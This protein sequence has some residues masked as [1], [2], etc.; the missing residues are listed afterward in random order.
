M[1]LSPLSTRAGIQT[2][3]LIT[4]QNPR[5]D[6]APFIIFLLSCKLKS[7]FL[8]MDSV[9]EIRLCSKTQQLQFPVSHSSKEFLREPFVK[10][11][12]CVVSAHS[13]GAKT[14]LTHDKKSR[15]KKKDPA[16]FS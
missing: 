16:E 13:C 11:L 8:S 1:V 6:P 15:R 3:A 10:W 12:K 7:H 9:P 2:N 4:S 14:A 5:H